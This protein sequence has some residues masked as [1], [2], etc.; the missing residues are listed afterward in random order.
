MISSLA[1]FER[2]IDTKYGVICAFDKAKD[3]KGLSVV[4]AQ[5]LVTGALVA[6]KVM[7]VSSNTEFAEEAAANEVLPAG[8]PRL[9]KALTC[10]LA[11]DRMPSYPLFGDGSRLRQYNYMVMPLAKNGTLLDLLLLDSAMSYELKYHLCAHAAL[12]VQALFQAGLCHK[13]LKPDNFVVLEGNQDQALLGLI[14]F[15]YC[16]N[17]ATVTADKRGTPC[18]APPEAFEGED[19]LV[20]PTKFDVFMLGTLMITILFRDTPFSYVNDKR[21]TI[22]CV[23]SNDPWYE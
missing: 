2:I 16:V 6:V 1:H 22:R 12:A 17:N 21:K 3:K 9:V 13:D 18:Y 20:D 15:G 5:C 8:N 23:C 11:R 7:A 10:Q 14:D 19:E 4:K